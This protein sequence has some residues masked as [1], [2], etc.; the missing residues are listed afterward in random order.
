MSIRTTLRRGL[1]A[2]TTLAATTALVVS[3]AVPATADPAATTLP[4]AGDNNT[5]VV[6]LLEGPAG[7]PGTGVSITPTPGGDPIEGVEFRLTLHPDIDLGTHAGW[8]AAYNLTVGEFLALGLAHGPTQVTDADGV[9]RFE[10]LAKGLWLVTP[11][12]TADAPDDLVLPEPFMVTLPMR[13]PTE[14]GVWMDTV[15]AYPKASVGGHNITKTLDSGDAV[16]V[17]DTMQWTITAGIPSGTSTPITSYIIADILPVHLSPVRTG[18]E[19]PVVTIVDAAGDPVGAPLAAPVFA[20]SWN[21]PV[22]YWIFDFGSPEGLALL[23]SLAPGHSVRIVLNTVI[24]SI[25]ADGTITNNASFWP[26]FNFGPGDECPTDH[27][28][29][30]CDPY[31]P[32]D[33]PV[34]HFAGITIEKASADA[35]VTALLPGATFRVFPSEAAARAFAN[36]PSVGGY[37]ILQDV[38]DEEAYEFTTGADGRVVIRGLQVSN[39]LDDGTMITCPGEPA[40]ARCRTFWLLETLA[41]D[42]HLL[43]AAPVPFQVTGAAGTH[44]QIIEIENIPDTAFRLPMTGGMGIA[45]ITAVGVIVLGGAAAFVVITRR[46]LA[47]SA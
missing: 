33:P 22:G 17:G 37:L 20:E 6:T 11:H 2:A 21:T 10:G 30:P 42:G 24:E 7:A 26:N 13:H 43:L 28:D 8:L 25:P 34:A 19:A 14:D 15:Y 47:A 41:P 45:L 46:R 32:Y 4:P 27:P 44:T 23:N 31:E 5:L 39:R 38:D 16:G 9:A 40:D 36:D 3:G 12:R 29:Y 35:N 1:V 18:T